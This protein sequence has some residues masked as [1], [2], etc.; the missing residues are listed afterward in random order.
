MDRTAHIHSMFHG[1]KPSKQNPK[2]FRATDTNNQVICA[3]L[4]I[5]QIC[6]EKQ[7][8]IKGKQSRLTLYQSPQRL[9]LCST[10]YLS[11]RFSHAT[12]CTAVSSTNSF[13]AL[14]LPDPLYLPSA[15]HLHSSPITAEHTPQAIS[16]TTHVHT[17][18][19]AAQEIP[20]LHVGSRQT[21]DRTSA[22]S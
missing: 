6:C 12:A 3:N 9:C 22:K 7:R 19:G 10:L 18:I 4:F 11:V 15:E 21:E 16:M 2:T 17:S 13:S 8:F 5:C 1:G 14:S 20:E